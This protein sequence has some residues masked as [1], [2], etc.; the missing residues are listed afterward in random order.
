MKPL[1]VLIV[2]MAYCSCSCPDGPG[3]LF[4]SELSG[5]G[6][7][8]L[9]MP[10]DSLMDVR[11]LTED[12]Y[13]D[14]VYREDVDSLLVNTILYDECSFEIVSI[15]ALG[16]SISGIGRDSVLLFCS[17]LYG[18]PRNIDSI[19]SKPLWRQYRWTIRDEVYVELVFDPISM[20][21][22]SIHNEQRYRYSL[23]LMYRDYV[24]ESI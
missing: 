12:E 16:N 23:V 9:G 7:L 3:T 18:P 10:I 11:K 20:I 1:L 17:R 8:Y 19:D 5:S 14:H 6:R 24:P 21:E 4:P 15:G 22:S 2:A 13:A